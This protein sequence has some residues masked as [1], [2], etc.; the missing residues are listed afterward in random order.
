[1]IRL[2]KKY[3]VISKKNWGVG[4]ILSLIMLNTLYLM[5]L[6]PIILIKKYIVAVYVSIMVLDG[7]LILCIQ[8][9]NKLKTYTFNTRLYDYLCGV[10]SDFKVIYDC[11]LLKDNDV[12]DSISDKIKYRVILDCISNGTGIMLSIDSFLT[13]VLWF[14]TALLGFISSP[15][16]ILLV[17][18]LI[19]LFDILADLVNII[20]FRAT[21]S[22]WASITD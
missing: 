18:W 9:N 20:I 3:C 11:D 13:L 19:V 1:M 6:S 7:I 22:L 14:L 8:L 16:I 21:I 17:C 15:P 12:E 2:F 4:L 5:E 10:V